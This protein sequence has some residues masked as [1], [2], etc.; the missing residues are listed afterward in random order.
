MIREKE[1]VVEYQKISCMGNTEKKYSTCEL[2]GENSWDISKR[3]KHEAIHFNRH[4]I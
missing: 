2:L 4:N 3:V 1:S